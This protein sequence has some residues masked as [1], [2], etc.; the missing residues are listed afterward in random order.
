MKRFIGHEGIV[1]AVDCPRC[2][3]AGTTAASAGDDRTVRLWDRRVRGNVGVLEHEYQVTAVAYG[4]DGNTV[5]SAGIDNLINA[6]DVRKAGGSR[7]GDGGLGGQEGG[8]MTMKMK[9]HTDTITSLSLSPKGTHLLSN[10]M[11]GTL[12]TWDIRPFVDGG[13]GKRQCKT[14]EGATHNAEKGLLNCGWSSDGMMV[15][16]G[17]ADKIV[18]I[19]DEPTSEEVSWME[20]RLFCPRFSLLFCFVLFWFDFTSF[21]LEHTLCMGKSVIMYIFDFTHL[22]CFCVSFSFCV[23]CSQ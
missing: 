7:S 2:T 10:S 13:G 6:W 1:N 18:H 12:K 20:E 15:T 5:Y 21:H 11:D 9:G 16:G 14:F 23:F 22:I 8:S 19:W 3:D 4:L 17:S